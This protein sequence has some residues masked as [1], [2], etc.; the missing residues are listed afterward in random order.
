MGS[1]VLRKVIIT[2]QL[3]NNPFD[4]N[5]PTYGWFHGWSGTSEFADA[6]IE[7]ENGIVR[8]VHMHDFHFEEQPQ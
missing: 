8:T 4:E 5:K 7:F 1:T 6:I 3:Y 2:G